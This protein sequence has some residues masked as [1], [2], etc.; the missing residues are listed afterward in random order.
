DVRI[1]HQRGDQKDSLPHA[2]RISAHLDVLI[3]AKREQVEELVSF[4]CEGDFGH[5][6]KRSNHFEIFPASEVRIEIRFF[7]HVTQ[8]PAISD[9]ILLDVAAG[10]ADFSLSWLE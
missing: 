9:E 5:F 6:A 10:E 3:P 4:G 8:V 1:I 2:F 7:G